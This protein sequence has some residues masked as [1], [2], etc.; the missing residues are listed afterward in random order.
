MSQSIQKDHQPRLSSKLR[1]LPFTSL[2][3]VIRPSE[4]KVSSPSSN[5]ST[6]LDAIH[7]RAP[8]YLMVSL[9]RVANL[10]QNSRY[11]PDFP[12]WE[13]IAISGH[14]TQNI[15]AQVRNRHVSLAESLRLIPFWAQNQLYAIEKDLNTP[16]KDILYSHILVLV[17]YPINNRGTAAGTDPTHEGLIPR[18]GTRGATDWMKAYY[19]RVPKYPSG[20]APARLDSRTGSPIDVSSL[21]KKLEGTNLALHESQVEPDG[22]GSIKEVHQSLDKWLGAAPI[23]EDESSEDSNIADRSILT[24]LNTPTSSKPIPIKDTAVG[25]AQGDMK[26]DSNKPRRDLINSASAGFVE[27]RP[28]FDADTTYSPGSMSSSIGLSYLEGFCDRLNAD[29][30]ESFGESCDQF[31]NRD[32][33]EDL[34]N[35]FSW[36]L[37]EEDILSILS[38]KL[39]VEPPNTSNSDMDLEDEEQERQPFQRPASVTAEWLS[40]LEAPSLESQQ[41]T[42]LSPAADDIKLSDQ[43]EEYESFVQ[44][45]GAYQWLLSKL[46]QDYRLGPHEP[47]IISAISIEIHN[48]F[49][50]EGTLRKMSRNGS[51]TGVSMIFNFEWSPSKILQAHNISHTQP[52]LFEKLLSFTGTPA[53]AQAMTIA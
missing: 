20:I 34:L 3:G 30:A 11:V 23:L 43:Y 4:Q 31:A 16:G 26:F 15:A 27:D 1:P 17:E 14:Y 18:I 40:L 39:S 47:D 5:F 44:K 35:K 25:S 37:H 28:N 45:S 13:M 46:R 8:S 2:H 51:L 42:M 48:H 52:D 33:L 53:N 22:Q 19:E 21:G 24:R 49:R 36:K 7:A 12:V 10:D 38:R 29:L 50:Q 9:Y 32:T 41:A 6:S